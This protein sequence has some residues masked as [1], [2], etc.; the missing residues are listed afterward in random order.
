MFK[1]LTPSTL[2]RKSALIAVIALAS[3]SA[4]LYAATIQEITDAG[5]ART[6]AAAADQERLLRR[7]REL[8]EE[9]RSFV[10][11]ALSDSDS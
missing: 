4:A 3:S 1:R 7:S 11:V 10:D 5:E 2:A 6:D 9:V 8:A